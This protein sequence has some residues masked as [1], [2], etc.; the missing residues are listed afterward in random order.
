MLAW[1]LEDYPTDPLDQQ[2]NGDVETP[3]AVAGVVVAAA[4]G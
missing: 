3:E 4:A 1:V 2:W